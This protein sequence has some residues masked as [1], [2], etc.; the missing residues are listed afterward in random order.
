MKLLLKVF[1][2]VKIALTIRGIL[3]NMKM[4]DLLLKNYWRFQD[5]NSRA[6]NQ[7]GGPS[8][9]GTLCSCPAYTPM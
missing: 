6:R 9:R 3:Y 5:G 4:G 7:E 1:V 8:E 2:Y